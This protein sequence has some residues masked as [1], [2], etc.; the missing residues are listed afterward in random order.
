[1]TAHVRER[2]SAYID[3]E[4]TASERAGVEVHLRECA[5]CAAAVEEMRAVDALARAQDVE[6]PAGYFD[7]LPG[8]VRTRVAPPARV[9]VPAWTL[10]LA[11]GLAV[12]V[13]APLVLKEKPA[14]LPAAVRESA[15]GA[16]PAAAA[17]EPPRQAPA[18]QREAFSVPAP[19]PRVPAQSPAADRLERRERAAAPASG[20]PAAAAPP[21]AGARAPRA[22]ARP[23]PARSVAARESNAGTD[24]RALEGDR[25]RWA[26]APAPPQALVEEKL[27]G[28]AGAAAGVEAA[29]PEEEEEDTPAL[30]DDSAAERDAAGAPGAAPGPPP[31]AQARPG[32]DDRFRS[33]STRAAR[34]AGEARALRDAWLALV[35]D[36]PE[37]P[38]AD[39]ARFRALEAGAAAWRLGGQRED[40]ALVEQAARDYLRRPHGAHK[41]RVRALLAGLEP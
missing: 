29:E 14:P 22:A 15:P 13:V 26:D 5:E 7:T 28:A 3:R 40:R 20:P 17:V 34:S 10:A 41:E 36:D 18:P 33:L 38:H 30:V 31:A 1:M 35:R 6:A 2:V 39:D 25:A 24:A 8:R 12:A 21:T 37:G 16:P 9:R 27:D 19:A 23:E 4:L 11:A 32:A